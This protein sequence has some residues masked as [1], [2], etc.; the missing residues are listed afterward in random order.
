MWPQHICVMAHQTNQIAVGLMPASM[1][2]GKDAMRQWAVLQPD[3]F[4]ICTVVR[5]LSNRF[6]T[7]CTL[8]DAIADH[9]AMTIETQHTAI[10]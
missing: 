4:H 7:V 1:T 3:V 9:A 6:P 8:T 2:S 10:P 5:N